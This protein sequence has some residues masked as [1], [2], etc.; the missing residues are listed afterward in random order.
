[1]LAEQT[2]QERPLYDAEL[3]NQPILVSVRQAARLTGVGTTFMWDLVHRGQLPSVRLG[4]RVLIPRAA[5]ERLARSHER[6]VA[7]PD[8]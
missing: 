3:E 6:V 5:I 2:R 8:L 7:L 1:M 4:R